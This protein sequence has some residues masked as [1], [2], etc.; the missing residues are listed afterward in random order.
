MQFVVVVDGRVLCDQPENGGQPLLSDDAE[1]AW[2]RARDA[3]VDAAYGSTCAVCECDDDEMCEYCSNVAD[4]RTFV[5]QERPHERPG[6]V[7]ELIVDNCWRS[8]VTVR[9]VAHWHVYDLPTVDDT[10]STHLDFPDAAQ[11]A[12]ELIDRAVKKIESNADGYASLGDQHRNRNGLNTAAYQCYGEAFLALRRAGELRCHAVNL[13]T[14]TRAA[15]PLFRIGPED[16]AAYVAHADALLEHSLRHA[17]SEVRGQVPGLVDIL[18]CQDPAC[19][20]GYR[21]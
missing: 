19:L 20:A 17:W 21:E 8:K 2:M 3:A 6:T 11:M 10:V 16:S 14:C 9:P 18:P 7:Y 13:D 15:A 12:S 1:S 5:N 4:I